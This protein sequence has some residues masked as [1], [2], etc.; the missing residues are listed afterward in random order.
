MQGL[1]IEPRAQPD[2]AYF[3]LV[4]FVLTITPPLG[5]E[6]T[7]VGFD[8]ILNSWDFK[9]RYSQVQSPVL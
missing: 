9:S 8:Y 7:V 2:M 3:E 6:R 1:G 4:G 5:I